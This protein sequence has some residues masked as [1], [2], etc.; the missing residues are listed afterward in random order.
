MGMTWPACKQFLAILQVYWY[1]LA[2][3]EKC[4]CVHSGKFAGHV[5]EGLHLYGVGLYETPELLCKLNEPY[6]K[7]MVAFFILA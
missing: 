4:F 5:G 7:L 3:R 6:T 1:C 2:G